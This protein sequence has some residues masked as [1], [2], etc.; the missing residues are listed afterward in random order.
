MQGGEHSK[1]PSD[2]IYYSQ[3]CCYYHL[4][5]NIRQLFLLSKLQHHWEE[6]K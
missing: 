1:F 6:N 5:L 4:H 2:T 3:H